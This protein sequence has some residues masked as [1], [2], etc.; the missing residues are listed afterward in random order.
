MIV[1]ARTPSLSDRNAVPVVEYDL[2]FAVARDITDRKRVED[3]LRYANRALRCISACNSAL[4]IAE[5]ELELVR[6]VCR[7]VVEVGGYRLA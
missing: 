1:S 2:V 7:V 3:R 6:E 4:F 5:T